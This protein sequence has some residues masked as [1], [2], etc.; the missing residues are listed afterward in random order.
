M[1]TLSGFN[2][3]MTYLT[4]YSKWHVMLPAE[5]QEVTPMP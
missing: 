2:H 4:Y 5:Q 3:E 1:Y